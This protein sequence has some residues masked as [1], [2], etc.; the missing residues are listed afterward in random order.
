MK[1]SAIRVAHRHLED[2]LSHQL[3]LYAEGLV[4]RLRAK[5]IPAKVVERSRRIEV[6]LL[7]LDADVEVVEDPRNPWGD[8]HYILH[9][10]DR[11]VRFTNEDDILRELVDLSEDS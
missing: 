1:P 2:E 8:P 11:P 3:T 5:R 4:D 7:N 6:D 9:T 10:D